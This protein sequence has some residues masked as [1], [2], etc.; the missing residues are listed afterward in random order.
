MRYNR[1]VRGLALVTAG[2]SV[3]L[4]APTPA[5][6]RTATSAGG[7]GEGALLVVRGAARGQPLPVTGT[8]VATYVAGHLSWSFD[9][10]KKRLPAG[11]S[12]TLCDVLHAV[13]PNFDRLDV[14]AAAVHGVAI[15]PGYVG[16]A[17]AYGLFYALAVIVLA[18]L[19][20]ER[21]EFL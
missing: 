14:K 19:V 7:P 16:A 4:A 21:R 10:L 17:A 3:V 15:A 9:L 20:F 5:A 1:V 18:C 11:P 12:R 8:R 2:F 6:G 13:L